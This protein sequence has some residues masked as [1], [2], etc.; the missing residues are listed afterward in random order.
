LAQANRVVV[1]GKLVELDTLRHTP[2]GVSVVKF[3]LQHD[4]SQSEAGGER[5]VS[6]E[7]AAVAF[8]REAKLLTA[9]KLGSNLK[10]TGFLAA[11]SRASR[12]LV[13]HAAQ[14]EFE[15]GA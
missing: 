3:R 1:S 13:L 8:E 5:K 14:I 15:Q 11:R 10:V 2:A 7:I 9:A 6:C 12:A 4:S